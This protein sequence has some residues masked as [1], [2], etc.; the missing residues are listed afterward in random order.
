[1]IKYLLLLVIS[2]LV[3]VQGFS[4]NRTELNSSIALYN[5]AIDRLY[6]YLSKDNKIDTLYVEVMNMSD[7]KDLSNKH[8]IIINEH[9]VFQSKR[10]YD[11]YVLRP[12][13][14]KEDVL[15]IYFSYYSASQK[16]K[17]KYYAKGSDYEIVYEY[18]CT[19]KEWFYKTID[20]YGF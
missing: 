12:I 6:E 11:V 16:R 10:K 1:M 3:Y 13:K 15:K 18:N 4:Q 20:S 5:D 2:L 7:W 8:G 17:M 19:S 14:F 9:F